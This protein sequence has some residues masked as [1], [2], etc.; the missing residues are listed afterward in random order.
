MDR[1]FYEPRRR[2]GSEFASAMP[3]NRFAPRNDSVNIFMKHS[4]SEASAQPACY[5]FC[6]V[7]GICCLDFSLATS[8][9]NDEFAS[10]S[11]N[12]AR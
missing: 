12:C 2:R 11:S 10:I 3:R 5:F 9:L 8:S 4:S 1:G 6:S 7:I